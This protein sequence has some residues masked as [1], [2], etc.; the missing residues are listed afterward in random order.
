[1]IEIRSGDRRAAFD[2]PFEIYPTS[3][4]Y[5]SPMWSDID[6]LLDCQKNPLVK[7][8]H[9]RLE[10][11][12]AH[13]N[14]RP[15]GRIVVTIHTASNQRHGT[16]KAQFGFFDCVDDAQ[17]AD[18]LIDVAE[19][20]ALEHGANELSG[21]FNLT[22]MQMI[23]VVTGGFENIPYTDIMWSPAHIAEHLERRGFARHFP[24]TTFETDLKDL[25]PKSLLGDRQ[26]A[27]LTDPAYTWSPINRRTFQTRMEDARQLLNDGFDSNPMFVPVT[28]AEYKYQAGEMM[29]I[30]DPR[31]SVVVH[32]HGKPAGVIVCIPD[33]NTFLRD[34]QSRLS[35][36]TL[37]H[38]LR[39]RMHR[40]R[41]VIIY[42]SVATR[43]HGHGLNGAMLHRLVT[44]A[45]AAGY[46][47]LGTTWIAD[48]NVASLRQMER[49][50]AR[51]L[52]HLHLF[53][54][55]L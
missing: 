9:G 54:R 22:A 46:R 50:G 21:N 18:A 34:T 40:D 10:L 19:K 48:I 6:R 41:A 27:I 51:P 1:M 28:K 2:V 35:L 16:N 25:D 42:Y 31:L 37:Y 39:H 8:G 32:H 26:E 47:K 45:K 4:P 44:Q 13:R 14:G 49:M 30:M 3:S 52:H 36:S 17:V 11:F 12:T 20:C 38:Y 23:G 24:M 43:L 29:W 33:I 7:D 55:M 15:I 5:V 53:H